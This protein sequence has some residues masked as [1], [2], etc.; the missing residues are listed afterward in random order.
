MAMNSPY[1]P[2]RADDV[3]IN[4]T[5]FLEGVISGDDCTILKACRVNPE[6]PDPWTRDVQETRSM[7]GFAGI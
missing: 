4:R 7:N 1:Q 3:L 2:G 5:W 6:Y